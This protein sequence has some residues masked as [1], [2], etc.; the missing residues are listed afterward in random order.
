LAQW[1]EIPDIVKEGIQA[2]PVDFY[3]EIY[4][5]LFGKVTVDEGNTVWK[6]DFDVI[7]KKK[8]K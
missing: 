3:E 5:Y 8:K 2:R 7:D 4:D 6:K 1:D